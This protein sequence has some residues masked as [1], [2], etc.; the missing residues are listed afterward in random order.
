MRIQY[1]SVIFLFFLG[2]MI[3]GCDNRKSE[4]IQKNVSTSSVSQT[5]NIKTDPAPGRTK[6][7]QEAWNKATDTSG[8][9]FKKYSK[10]LP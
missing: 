3:T 9:D 6:E 1:T 2:F 10:P 4:T 8:H 5:Q 7:E